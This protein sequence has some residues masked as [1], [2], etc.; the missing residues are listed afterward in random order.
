M[1]VYGL[2]CTS[3]ILDEIFELIQNSD[4]READALELTNAPKINLW[5]KKLRCVSEDN[6]T[7]YNRQAVLRAKASL[8]KKRP[9]LRSCQIAKS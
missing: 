6:T 2:D 1:H 8:L 3:R 4:D 5:K 9:S 7:I